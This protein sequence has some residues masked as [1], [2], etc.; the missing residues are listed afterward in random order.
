MRLTKSAVGSQLQNSAAIDIS[1]PH[2]GD[3]RV[4][5]EAVASVRDGRT[6][7]ALGQDPRTI[8]HLV[9]VVP[10]TFKTKQ[11]AFVGRQEFSPLGPCPDST[12]HLVTVED[13]STPVPPTNILYRR[14]GN[15]ARGV[16]WD[17]SKTAPTSSSVRRQQR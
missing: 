5:A 1:R 12:P 9:S 16:K 7:I 14:C 8:A 2:S 4:R 15:A 13:H 10:I 11:D 6:P 3:P 17:R